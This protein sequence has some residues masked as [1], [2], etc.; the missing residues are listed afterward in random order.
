MFETEMNLRIGE[1]QPVND[2][3]NVAKLCRRRF[4]KL[5]PGGN[6]VK[7]VF[8]L[9]HSTHCGGSHLGRDFAF[10]VNTQSVGRI[11]T[12]RSGGYLKPRYRSDTRQRLRSE[13]HTSELQSLAY[14]VCRL[15]L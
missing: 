6:I 12:R 1:R 15:L 3:A 7:Q 2:I 14:L 10:A 4:Q 13:E 5:S 8:Q 9:D 11:I